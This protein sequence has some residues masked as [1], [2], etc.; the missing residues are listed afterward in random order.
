MD[1]SAIRPLDDHSRA[2]LRSGVLTPS[3]PSALVELVENA[4]DA[5]ATSVDVQVDPQAWSLR[6]VDDG[7]GIPFETL[8]RLGATLRSGQGGSTAGGASGPT[9]PSRGG[10][11]PDRPVAGRRGAALTAIAALSL[12]HVISRTAGSPHAG[13][14]ILR[15]GRLHLFLLLLRRTQ[16]TGRRAHLDRK[17]SC[18]YRLKTGNIRL[19]Q[20]SL[21]QCAWPPD[22]LP[23]RSPV[24][25]LPV[26]RS[27]HRDA[28]E[29]RVLAEC[30]E[31]IEQTAVANPSCAFKLRRSA[32]GGG[33]PDAQRLVIA[34]IPKVRHAGTEPAC[35][36]LKLLPSRPTTLGVPSV[37]CLTCGIKR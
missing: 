4:L 12:L 24:H 7:C 30:K 36:S 28:H 22:P 21:L 3:L 11:L 18:P 15:V 1:A 2:L 26:R 35:C 6:V 19:G 34:H 5:G 8:C 25:K 23:A 29:D 9:T 32:T 27:A 16:G 33:S 31:L 37:A 17:D 14:V 10:L 20:G 13:E